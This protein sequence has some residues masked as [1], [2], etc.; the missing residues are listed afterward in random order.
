[1]CIK[2]DSVLGMQNAGTLREIFVHKLRAHEAVFT[3]HGPFY[4]ET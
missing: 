2:V 1:M 4:S 3:E